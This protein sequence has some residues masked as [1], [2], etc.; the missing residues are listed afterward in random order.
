MTEPGTDI[1]IRNSADLAVGD[2]WIAV[3]PH[4]SKLAGMIAGT[5]FVPKGLRDKPA[6]VAAAILAGRESG[7]GPMTALQHMHV[8]EGR[9]AMSA[10]LKRARALA[11]GH[12]VVF[13]EMS[14]QRCVV[15]GRRQGSPEWTTVTWTM[16][17]ARN[18][19]LGNKDNWRNYP[20]R[21]LQARATSELCDLIFP[22]CTA[23][24][25]SVEELEDE[26]PE[27]TASTTGE[28]VADTTRRTT[29]RRTKASTPVASETTTGADVVPVTPEPA[30]PTDEPV[31]AEVV[32]EPAKPDEPDTPRVPLTDAQSR[33][34]HTMFTAIGWTG[35]P[36]RLDAVTAILGRPITSSNDL[37]KA[38]ASTVIDTLER[39]SYDVSPDEASKRLGNL[40]IQTLPEVATVGKFRLGGFEDAT[41]VELPTDKRGKGT[42]TDREGAD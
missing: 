14:S 32:A 9:P 3:M 23:G 26:N 27:Y 2:Q 29:R 15:K 34:L 4:V 6:A 39:I 21:M 40:V 31:D 10:E 22:D 20:R 19:K 28:T 38:E 18:A 12:E 24:L 16:E 25:P 33:K 42:P 36:D 35:R 7:V 30:L 8:V 11:A 13:V 37:S 1:E 5:E 41:V 17:D